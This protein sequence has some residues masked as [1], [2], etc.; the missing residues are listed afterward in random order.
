MLAR[1]TCSPYDQ[2]GYLAFDA[3]NSHN[4]RWTPY[5]QSGPAD[6]CKQ[7]APALA[8]SFL[9]ASWASTSPSHTPNLG[10]LWAD[11]PLGPDG[12]PW[13]DVEWARNKTVFFMGDSI[14]RFT[15]HYV[16]EVRYVSPAR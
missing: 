8:A 6:Q 3:D 11:A 13:Q 9:R 1:P 7:P 10:M 2:H 4:N 12:K 5:A 15:S 16:C 14:S